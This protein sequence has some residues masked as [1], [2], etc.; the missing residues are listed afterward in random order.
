MIAIS[1]HQLS[2]LFFNSQLCAYNALD[3]GTA[4]TEDVEAA[5]LEDAKAFCDYLGDQV[6]PAWLVNDFQKRV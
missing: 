4:T 3:H 5:L 2:D 6:D 1:E